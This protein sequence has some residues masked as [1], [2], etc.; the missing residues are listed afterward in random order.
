MDKKIIIFIG[1]SGSGKGTQV[2]L[3]K[4]Y[5]L[6]KQEEVVVLDIGSGVRKISQGTGFVSKLIKKKQE[7]GQL[8]PSA[9]SS[10]IWSEHLFKVYSSDRNIIIDGSPRQILE[11]KNL[12]EF[13]NFLDIKKVDVFYLNIKDE[14][15]FRRINLRRE[16]RA[17]DLDMEKINKR[18]DFFNTDVLETIDFIKKENMFN[19]YEIDGQKSVEEISEDIKNKLIS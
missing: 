17:D 2:S 12:K 7:S 1:K 16:G 5:F 13:F 14:E 10:Y 6:S 3:L 19:I 18:L 8:L 11:A 4:D 15:V 9:V